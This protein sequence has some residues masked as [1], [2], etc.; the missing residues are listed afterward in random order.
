[1]AYAA[2]RQIGTNRGFAIIIVAIVHVILGYALITGLAYNVIK[3]ATSEL[4]TFNV[5]EELVPPPEEPPPLPPEQVPD[6]PSPVVSPPPI[7]RTKAAP[8]VVQTVK[9]APPPVVTPRA[10]PIPPAPPAPP[11]LPATPPP[12]APPLPVKT[13]APQSASGDLQKLF[14]GNDYPQSAARAEE[15]GSVTV[16]LTVATSGRVSTCSITSSSGSRALD[17]AT[18]QILQSRA[19]FTP[20]RDNRGSPTT[21]TV[22]QRISWVL[23]G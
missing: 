20:A 5:E 12:P 2:S 4:K 13:V 21:D 7:V 9:D 14:H 23:E 1:V 18:C 22:T 10:A 15:H 6:T 11:T 17:R 8:S 19:R 3:Q 16:C